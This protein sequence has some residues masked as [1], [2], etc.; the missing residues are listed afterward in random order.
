MATPIEQEKPIMCE[1]C[2]APLKMGYG[3]TLV[4]CEYCG[5]SMTI[6][7]EVAKLISKHS[8][9]LNK[10]TPE[11][12]VEVAKRWMD[13]GIF[14]VG[15][16]K[17]ATITEVT[18]KYLPVWTV[19]VTVTGNYSASSSGGYTAD[20]RQMSDAWKEKDKKGFLKGLGKLAVKGA[21]IAAI[22]AGASKT[23]SSQGRDSRGIGLML[24]GG[25][26]HDMAGGGQRGV[27][28]GPISKQ[29]Y[30]LMFARRASDI[31]LNQYQIPL[32]EKEIFAIGKIPQDAEIL[33]GDMLEEEAKAKADALAR[34]QVRKELSHQYDTI[35]SL[36]LN[37][38]LGECELVHIPVWFVSYEHK[39]VNRLAGVDGITGKV[40]NGTRP[41]IS[42]GIL[43][44]KKET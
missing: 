10:I 13:S 2:G 3:A 16:S 42:L 29:Y 22:A 26:I 44:K 24:G 38:A 35:H 25:V 43:G 31:D 8:M 30:E 5:S 32:Q 19:P 27:A 39:G 20:V 36:N 12:A 23:I 21:A 4:T 15:V 33:N 9:L 11:Q 34:E 17:E 40:V 1:S 37:T 7:G 28:S 14:R 41:T 6:S 18:L